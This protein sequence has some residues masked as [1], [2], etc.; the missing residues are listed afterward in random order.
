VQITFDPAVPLEVAERAV[1]DAAPGDEFQYHLGNL[2]FDRHP[3]YPA[4]STRHRLY[5][6]AERMLRLYDRGI[7]DLVQ[8]RVAPGEYAYFA[9]RRRPKRVF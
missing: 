4:F 6:L 3:P 8:K 5:L 2:A 1:R 9:I 7:V